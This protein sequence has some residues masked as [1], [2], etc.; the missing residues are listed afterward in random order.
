MRYRG[1]Y[2]ATTNATH[3]LGLWKA[4]CQYFTKNTKTYMK[5]AVRQ[6]PDVVILA[7]KNIILPRQ[8]GTSPSR[9]KK[10]SPTRDEAYKPR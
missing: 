5:A 6:E 9:Q 1:L 2:G 4:T 3:S 10:F 8:S 7:A